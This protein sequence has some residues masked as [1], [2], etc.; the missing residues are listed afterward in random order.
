M[1]CGLVI[2]QD[3]EL[4]TF[5]YPSIATSAKCLLS[6]VLTLTVT[7]CGEQVSQSPSQSQPNAAAP[8]AKRIPIE[9]TAHGDTRIDN[10]YWM[11]DDS[12]TD[13]EV[14]AHLDAENAYKDAVLAPIMPLKQ[15]IYAEL[16]GRLSRDQSTV[17]ARDNGYWYYQRFADDMEYPVYARKKNLQSGEGTLL[18]TNAMA[19]GHD[20]FAIGGY[21]VSSNND[22]LAYSTD[23]VSRWQYQIRFKNLKTGELYPDILLATD[24]QAVWANDSQSVYYVKNDPQTLLGYQ[25]YRHSLGT[26]QGDDVLV[27]QEDDDSFYTSLGKSKDKSTIYIYHDS[28][29]SSAV[30]LMNANGLADAATVRSFLPREEDHRY[31]VAKLGDE[32]YIRSNWQAENFRLLKVGANSTDDKSSWREVVPHHADVY[33]EDF[34]VFDGYLATLEKRLGNA[35]LSV[36][37]LATG[38]RRAVSF[39]EAVFVAS[40]SD[41]HEVSSGQLRVAYRSPITPESIYDIDL[42]TLERSLLKQD[43]VLG[44]YRRENYRT[45]R[46]AIEARDGERVPVTLIY[47]ADKFAQDGSMPLYQY[48][49]GAYGANEEPSFYSSWVS[50]ADRGFL[51][52]IAHIR[53]GGM[54]GHRWYEAGKLSFK[55]NTFTDFIDVSRGL[56][57]QQY[58]DS[59][60]VYAVGGSAGGLLIGAIMN[61]AP[62]L[63]HG[64][65]A[66]V[67]FVDVITTMSDPSIPLTTNEYDE[68]GNPAEKSAYDYMLAYSPYDQVRATDYPHTLVTAGLH[69]SQVQYFEP[70]KWV[71][72]LREMKTDSNTL[73][74]AT[75]MTSGHSGASGR[76]KSLQEVARNYAFFVDLASR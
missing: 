54:L 60:R 13:P 49:Y 7:A 44:G 2:Q 34:V 59:E 67:P 37:T 12:R 76:F 38:Q 22:I 25:V 73:I 50:L 55:R 16:A 6:L 9:L 75:D 58:A 23:T 71:A 30:S 32:Y 36:I 17:P 4:V 70:M 68:W 62:S 61:M 47:R 56:I 5:Q 53:G 24:G 15:E 29:T 72:K 19:V 51:V 46:I 35:E 11:R 69:D 43:E 74:L 21:S 31:S 1:L 48:G 26:S 14:L 20:Y 18:D 33:L 27:Y 57:A 39:D 65:T 42:G 66:E 3:Y 8:V 63:Y 40:F 10:Y 45:Q 64:V 28:T 52:A 41:N